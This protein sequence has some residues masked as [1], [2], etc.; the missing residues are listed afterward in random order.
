MYYILHNDKTQ[1]TSSQITKKM[2]IALNILKFLLP[3][4]VSETKS[5]ENA[6]QSASTFTE[7]TIF[8]NCMCPFSV[9]KMNEASGTSTFLSVWSLWKVFH[10]H[11]NLLKS[12]AKAYA[13]SSVPKYYII[14]IQ[15]LLFWILE[16]P[17]LN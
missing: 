5:S 11:A 8:K 9:Q 14:C 17:R 1:A 16:S 3:Y 10:L 2:Q 13:V 12:H 15:F 4:T 7:K 6:F